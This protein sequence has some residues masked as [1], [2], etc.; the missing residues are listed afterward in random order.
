MIAQTWNITKAAQQ[1]HL[2]QQALSKSIGKLEEELGVTLFIRTE[3]QTVLTDIGQKLLPVIQ[4]LLRKYEEH[5]K[6]I[7][8][9]IVQNSHSV[10]IAFENTVLLN[11]FPAD[12][13]SRIGDLTITAYLGD[14][15]VSCMRDVL[16]HRATCAFILKP[17]DLRGLCYFPVVR[18]FPNV[19]MSRNHPL[20]RKEY[21]SIE[22]LRNENHAWLSIN[23]QSFQDYY[24]A[25][26]E[27][28]FYPKITREY[29]SA[30]LLH[31]EIPNGME[32]TIGGGLVFSVV[33]FPDLDAFDF[34]TAYR[35]SGLEQVV[36]D[37]VEIG[38][39]SWQGQEI[40]DILALK[41]LTGGK[42]VYHS[43]LDYATMVAAYNAKTA[44][45][46]D[47]RAF[48]RKAI[49]ETIVGGHYAPMMQPFNDEVTTVM[50]EEYRKVCKDY[51]GSPA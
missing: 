29:P 50:T 20:T 37:L 23:S 11:G 27:A 10:R 3:R 38:V 6:L 22:D 26:M 4:S 9:I 48:V 44:T 43:L 34:E 32:I 25:C 18:H 8:D 24:N 39:D 42:L 51:I 7:H 2:T 1:L 17:K 46:E 33:K 40:N 19:I 21:I 14:D 35:N 16:E 15:Y 45:M 36:P 31:Q 30:E 49:Q 47:V 12:F 41:K 13:L 28:G 5:E